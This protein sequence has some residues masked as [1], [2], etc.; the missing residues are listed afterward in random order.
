[1]I[2]A[3]FDYVRPKTVSEAE[4]Y[5]ET[6]NSVILAGGHS[7]VSALK[8]RKN[9]PSLV[10]DINDLSLNTIEKTGGGLTIGA[11]VRQ[12]QFYSGATTPVEELLQKVCHASGDPLIRSRGTLVGALCAAEKAGDWGAAALALDARLQ[13]VQNGMEEEVLYSD[14]LSND[15]FRERAKLVSAVKLPEL[16]SDNEVSYFKAKHAA[17]GWAIAGMA[18]VKGPDL[19]RIAV[20]G[21][22]H[23]PSR[24]RATEQAIQSGGAW[25]DAWNEDL[26]ELSLWGD[27]YASASYRVHVLKNEVARTFDL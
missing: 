6:T 9:R 1:M 12:A 5:L 8:W 17:I 7:L 14:W 3:Q 25:E 11:T 15:E 21:V 27:S 23:R 19:V 10:V 16:S 20:S 13:V 4:K 22:C 26:S 18:T 24:L 2:P